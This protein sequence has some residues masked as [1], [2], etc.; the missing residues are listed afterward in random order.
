MTVTAASAN[1]TLKPKKEGFVD[2]YRFQMR[3]AK[4]EKLEE[5]R[6]N[7]EADKQK[8]AELKNRRVFKPY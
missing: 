8:I 5:L 2:F 4:R 1:Q 3:Q 6:A 7:F